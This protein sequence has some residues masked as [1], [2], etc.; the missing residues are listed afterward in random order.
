MVAGET[1][2]IVDRRLVQPDWTRE[3]I[4]ALFDMPFNELVVR[5]AEV[6]RAHRAAGSCRSAVTVDTGGADQLASLTS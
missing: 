4:A 3:E 1:S 2:T 5:A 6:H